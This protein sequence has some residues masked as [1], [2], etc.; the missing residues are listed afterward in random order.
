MKMAEI[1]QEV[2]GNTQPWKVVAMEGMDG[3]ALF[4][5]DHPVTLSLFGKSLS[6]MNGDDPVLGVDQ[7]RVLPIMIVLLEV[8]V[9]L[10]GPRVK[11]S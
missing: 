6:T 5:V 7:E 1:M 8:Y 10:Q 2:E 4:G 9:L 3:E 11:L